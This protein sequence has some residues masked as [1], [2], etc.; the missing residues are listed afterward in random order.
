MLLIKS[1]NSKQ[2]VL[3]QALKKLTEDLHL[4]LV[5]FAVAELGVCEAEMVVFLLDR[6]SRLKLPLL[7]EGLLE[8]KIKTMVLETKN[9]GLFPSI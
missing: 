9:F 7:Q 5:A 8:R 1:N 4:K 3:D 6:Q 2:Q